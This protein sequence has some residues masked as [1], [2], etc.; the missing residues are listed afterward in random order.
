L[1][2]DDLQQYFYTLKIGEEGVIGLET[3]GGRDAEHLG[4][5]PARHAGRHF[6]YLRASRAPSALNPWF[7]WLR[8]TLS[9]LPSPPSRSYIK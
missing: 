7:F 6:G 3:S 2:R 4:I 1:N 8:R 5:R 9:D